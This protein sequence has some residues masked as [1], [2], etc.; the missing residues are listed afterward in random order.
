MEEEE[1]YRLTDDEVALLRQYPHAL[2]YKFSED[3]IRFME[4]NGYLLITVSFIRSEP[5]NSN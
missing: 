2:D 3:Q 5:L 4:D 1:R